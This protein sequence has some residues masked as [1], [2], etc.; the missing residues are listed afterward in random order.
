F[1]FLA[2]ALLDKTGFFEGLWQGVTQFFT[3]LSATS[4]GAIVGGLIATSG[5]VW[6]LTSSNEP[7]QP[8]VRQAIIER[9]NANSSPQAVIEQDEIPILGTNVLSS[10]PIK[11]TFGSEKPHSLSGYVNPTNAPNWDISV[12]NGI[13]V[14]DPKLSVSIVRAS[15]SYPLDPNYRVFGGLR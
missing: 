3:G 14:Y 15:I 7:V 1:P 5:G 9:Q 11:A 12:S 10:L 2:P 6:Y 13:A 4:I 8:V